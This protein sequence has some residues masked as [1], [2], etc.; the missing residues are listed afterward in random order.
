MAEELYNEG[1]VIGL[2][3]YEIFVKQA[4]AADVP[5]PDIPTESQWLTSM[6]GMGSSMILKI[7]QG[8]TAGIHDY[9]LPSGTNLSAAGVVIANPFL[10]EI[11]DDDWDVTGWAKKV[12]SYS[13]LISNTSTSYPTSQSVPSGTY[14]ATQYQAEITEFVKITDGIVYLNNATWVSSAD[15]PPQKDIDPN[16]NN[17]NAVVRI[18]IESN[19]TTDFNII[20]TGFLNK[21]ILQ[22]VSQYTDEGCSTNIN[23][24]DW[25]NGGMLGPEVIPWAS[26]IIFSYPNMAYQEAESTWVKRTIPSDASYTPS[27]ATT[28]YG[29]TFNAN[30]INGQV[31]SKPVID[32]ESIAI[33][34]YYNNHSFTTEPRL[35]ENISELILEDADSYGAL[36]AWYPGMSATKIAAS[37]TSST[38]FFP[39]ALYAVRLNS[40]GTGKTLVP[41]DTAAPGTVKCFPNSTQA[42]H[43]SQFLPYNYALYFNS[44][45]NTFSFVTPGDSTVNNWSGTSKLAYQTN[46]KVQL[47][48]GNTQP[49]KLMALSKSDGTDYATTGAA[50]DLPTTITPANKLVWGDLL[51]A[52]ADNKAIDLFGTKLRNF[53]TELNSN[54]N[55][56]ITNPVN[57][58][59]ANWI[60]LNP[61]PADSAKMV[62]VG[63]EVGSDDGYRYLHLYSGESPASIHLGANFIRFKAATGAYEDIKLYISS[64][65]P[66]PST[67]YI[68][69]G[70][71]GI[72][73]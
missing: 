36:V 52:L 65:E 25:K 42:Y 68:P 47:S 49:V 19:V 58:I 62:W 66:D 24:N 14:S 67:E 37:A 55:I 1:R 63:S 20:F 57:Y 45:N 73:W 34:D 40:T 41:M 26:K 69:T 43:Y 2:S 13:P 72:G 60:K 35:Q 39:P 29:Y 44:S 32:L 46:P 16:F 64:V 28:K 56:G 50:G 70:S 54:N 9:V 23:I 15:T 6:I 17:S 27:T 10:G 21:R 7:P 51:T 3:A 5:Q 53:A 8:T 12:K 48:V 4:L 11:D 38:D 22:A 61:A 31:K 30:A 33:N 18:Y 59:G 71:I